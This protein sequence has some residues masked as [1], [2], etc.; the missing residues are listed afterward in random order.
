MLR[1]AQA[2]PL[3][4]F[5]WVSPWYYIGYQSA[6]YY[7]YIVAYENGST[8]ELVVPV[9]NDPAWGYTD[10]LNVSKVI[11]NF[12]NIGVNKTLDYYTSPHQIA[13][14][15]YELFTISF[16][17]NLNEFGVASWDHEYRIIVE[18]VN[19]TLA[20]YTRVSPDFMIYWSS[21]SPGYKFVVVSSTQVDADDSLSEYNAYYSEYSGY[22]WQTFAAREKA[23]EAEIEKAIGDTYYNRGNF[24][25]AKTQYDRANNLWDQAIA[26][27]GEWRSINDVLN[28]NNTRSQIAENLADAE[29]TLA[30]AEAALI[31]AQASLLIAN[32]TIIQAE[33]AMMN[34]WGFYFIGL[35]FALGWSFIGIGVIIYALRK[36]KLPT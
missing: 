5:T 25:L 34:A 23:T 26:A 31:Q 27:E 18:H 35:G 11:L 24:D 12:Y 36:P 2:Y 29:A 7:D 33:A 16:T 19:A 3:T 17:T 4:T 14:N 13:H 28:Q 8:A 32:A 6:P 15:Q 20:P 30:M 1:S 22:S 9:W 21:V 10:G